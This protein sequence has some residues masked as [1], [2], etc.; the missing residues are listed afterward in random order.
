MRFFRRLPLS[1]EGWAWF[2]TGVALFLTG[3]SKSIN[4]ITLLACFMLA[5]T[6]MNYWL[7][8]R[9]LRGLL[10]SRTVVGPVFAEQPFSILVNLQNAA[11][12]A[13]VGVHIQADE[14]QHWF[15]PSMPGKRSIELSCEATLAHR[16][17]HVLPPLEA[18]SGHPLGFVHTSRT[19]VEGPNVVVLP[20]PGVLYRGRLRQFL[21]LASPS[22]GDSR[23]FPRRHPEAQSEFHGLREF[24]AGDSP[25]FIHWRTSARRGELMVREFEDVPNDDLVLILEPSISDGAGATTLETAI[26]VAATICWEWCRQKG[27]R[28]TLAIA[29]AKSTILTGTTGLPHAMQMLEALAVEQGS[30]ETDCDLLDR[31]AE[32]DVKASPMLVVTTRESSLP[33]SLALHFH[34]PAGCI[35]VGA[36][37]YRDFC[38]L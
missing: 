15:I 17:Q 20:R 21:N 9:Q 2:L 38:E 29:G 12:S 7:A 31:L 27:D 14:R 28:F 5:S 22:L 23:T 37:E 24:R 36:G 8:R 30:R 35:N 26:R 19:L 34:R 10:A 33:A 18:W 6:G 1:R 13:R 32:V 25:R 4:L 3:Y 16:G 11:R